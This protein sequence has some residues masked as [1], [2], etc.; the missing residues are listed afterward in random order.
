[1]LNGKNVCYFP[2]AAKLT[3]R[4]VEILQGLCVFLCS[5]SSGLGRKRSFTRKTLSQL[6]EMVQKGKDHNGLDMSRIMRLRVRSI[7]GD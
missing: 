3:C 7:F 4:D 2:A 1:M 5:L 6:T